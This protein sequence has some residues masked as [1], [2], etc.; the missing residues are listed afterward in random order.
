M[1]PG[2]MFYAYYNYSVGTVPNDAYDWVSLFAHSAWY[3][4]GLVYNSGSTW[5]YVY[6]TEVSTIDPVAHFYNLFCC[7]AGLYTQSSNAGCLAGH[8]VFSKTHSL[9]VIASTKTGS[10][11]NFADFYAPLANGASIGD[12]F[13]DWFILNAETGAGVDS[14]S[15]FYGMSVFGD[16]TLDTHDTVLPES[17]T[18]QDIGIEQDDVLLSWDAS[19]SPDIHHYAIYRSTTPDTF[20]YGTPYHVTSSDLNPIGCTWRDAGALEGASMF[21]VVRAVDHAGNEDDNAQK[22]GFY[23]IQMAMND[24]SLVSVPLPQVSDDILDVFENAE[25]NYAMWFDITDEDHWKT[26]ATFKPSGLNDLD[27]VNRAMGVWL[28]GTTSDRLTVIGTEPQQT[29]IQLKAGWNLVGYPSLTPKT[30]SEALS[31]ISYDGV[32]S[33]DAVAPYRISQM[34]PADLMEPGGG[35]WIHVSADTAWTIDW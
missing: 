28:R 3:Y 15:W 32:E 2:L 30:V 6:N 35:Y 31:G 25:W 18:N 20:D 1:D 7:S 22:L 34:N 19:P 16:P 13:L 29:L 9:S 5:S 26:Y 10:M 8:Y 27:T 4:H 12:A 23:N 24:W 33:F 11:L 17:P 14:R 21:Y